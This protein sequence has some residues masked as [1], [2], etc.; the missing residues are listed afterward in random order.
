MGEVDIAKQAPNVTRMKILGAKIVPV[1]FGLKTLKEAV[2]SA[3]ESYARNYRDSIYCIG[4]ALGP[5]PFPLMVRD[6]QYCI[7]EESR[8]QFKTMTGSCRMRSAPASAA[9]AIRPVRSR[10]S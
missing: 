2:D 7:G 5:H 4:S 3:F 8:E 6:F 9:A 10:P 1:S